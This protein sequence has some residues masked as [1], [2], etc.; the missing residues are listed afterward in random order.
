MPLEEH[1]LW[2]H[3]ITGTITVF[4]LIS[5]LCCGAAAMRMASRHG[6]PLSH[7]WPQV[8]WFLLLMVVLCISTFQSI[9]ELQATAVS[10]VF[11]I[12]ALA[13]T[14]LVLIESE[15]HLRWT[16]LVAIGAA[17]FSSIYAIRQQQHYGDIVANFRTGG[18]SGDA[19]YYALMVGLW[20]PIAFVW[21]TGRRPLWERLFCASCL[22]L[23]LIGTAFAAS[24][25]GFLGLAASFLYLIIRS[26]RPFYNGFIAGIFALPILLGPSS[27]PLQRFINPTAG[28]RAAEDAR[29]VAWKSGLRMIGAHPLTGVGLHNFKSVILQYED[30]SWVPAEDTGYEAGVV[31]LAHN[32]YMEIAAETGLPGIILFVA[33]LFTS[34]R[35]L[36][37][38]RHR[39]YNSKRWHLEN[40]AMG[41]QGGLLSFAVSAFFVTAWWQKMFWLLLFVAMALQNF[42]LTLRRVRLIPEGPVHSS[43]N[44]ELVRTPRRVVDG[45]QS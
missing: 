10:H 24:R 4:K 31:S 23:M 9:G 42:S 19:N 11:S 28:D 37:R 1:W 34:F 39:A 7:Y 5:L 44:S 16:L 17:G 32:T 35:N 33:V 27:S 21:A 41:L 29:I 6:I 38:L 3:S 13:L 30:P 8:R 40:L 22:G 18:I 25:G 43:G 2:G 14:T 36:E 45:M 15:A 12:A 26:R 20:V